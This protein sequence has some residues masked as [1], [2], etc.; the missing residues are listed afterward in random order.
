MTETE[1]LLSDWRATYAEL[2]PNRE[3][4]SMQYT[5]AMLALAV[6]L[7][8]EM[9]QPAAAVRTRVTYRLDRYNGNSE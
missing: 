1:K 5:D 8:R 6:M 2:N 7:R 9:R 4:D 3:P